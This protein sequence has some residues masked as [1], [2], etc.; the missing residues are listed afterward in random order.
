M[1]DFIE[2]TFEAR[3]KKAERGQVSMGE[4]SSKAM[5]QCA[6]EQNSF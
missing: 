4:L 6:E 3:P 1:K 5:S 2:V